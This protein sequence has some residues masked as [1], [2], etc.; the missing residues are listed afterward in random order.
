MNISS[1]Q[2]RKMTVL[3][4][5]LL[6]TF[7]NPFFVLSQSINSDSISQLENE[8]T[9]S[10]INWLMYQQ[11][12]ISWSSNFIAYDLDKKSISKEYF[13]EKLTSGKYFLIKIGTTNGS[14]MYQLRNGDN[15]RDKEILDVV[16]ARSI[17]EY[18]YYKWE[19]KYLPELNF[20]DIYGNKLTPMNTNGK[21]LVINCWFTNC[22]PCVA[23]IPE[24]NKLVKYFKADTSILFLAL[25]FDDKTTL[26]SFLKNKKF[27]Y[28]I[29]PDKKNY[30]MNILKIPSYPTHIIVDKNGIIKK[31][32]TTDLSTLK[33][34]I[35]SEQ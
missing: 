12:N 3:I 10:T 1:F 19:G 26:E 4:V 13:Y 16:K 33:Q 2:I 35:L 21:T 34:L 25:A 23:E 27:N 30:L 29:I 24:L 28:T 7:L 14:N 31:I 18:N 9:S 6:N 5:F 8:I 11:N 15:A 32:T 20:E 22:V 17:L